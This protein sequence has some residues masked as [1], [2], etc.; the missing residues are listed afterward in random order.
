MSDSFIRVSAPFVAQAVSDFEAKFSSWAMQNEQRIQTAASAV[1]AGN[2][3]ALGGFRYCVNSNST[4]GASYLVDCQAKSCQC[5]W[6]KHRR[7]ICTHRLTVHL[8]VRALE[9]QQEFEDWL[10]RH[11]EW[12]GVPAGVETAED[13]RDYA[14]IQQWDAVIETMDAV[15]EVHQDARQEMGARLPA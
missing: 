7:S 9:M 3:R 4:M 11:N 1:L 13:L 8:A 5:P 2:V 6:F 14:R 15:A 10:T 12:L